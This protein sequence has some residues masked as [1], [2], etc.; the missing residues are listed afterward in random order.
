MG[1]FPSLRGKLADF[2]GTSEEFDEKLIR[3]GYL[4]VDLDMYVRR[5]QLQ[6]AYGYL[7]SESF[8]R[9]TR[10]NTPPAISDAIY[11][12]DEVQ[13]VAFRIDGEKFE[14]ALFSLGAQDE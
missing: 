8:P 12:L 10:S 1:S 2:P 7:V 5:F 6:E 9:L 3:G 14:R 4:D 13:L 11:T